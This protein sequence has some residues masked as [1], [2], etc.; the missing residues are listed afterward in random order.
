MS[1]DSQVTGVPERVRRLAG[2]RDFFAS[3][4]VG[5]SLY[6]RVAPKALSLAVSR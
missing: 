1:Y 6:M 2:H 5:S 4:A 3:I